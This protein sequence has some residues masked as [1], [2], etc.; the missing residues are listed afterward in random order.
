WGGPL[1]QHQVVCIM[2]GGMGFPGQGPPGP[3]LPQPGG[4]ASPAGGPVQPLTM[5]APATAFSGE[6][7]RYPWYRV[8]FVGGVD[9]RHG[10]SVEAP[11][12]G[13]TL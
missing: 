10:P 3:G 13:E 6:A 1:G 4:P 11:R 5:I 12:T 9:L 7:G 2:Q 8:S